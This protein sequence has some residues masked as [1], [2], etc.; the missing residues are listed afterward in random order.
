VCDNVCIYIAGSEV[1]SNCLADK[2]K[3]AAGINTAC[4]VCAV[5]KYQG[6]GRRQHKYKAASGVNL[7]CDICEA[8]KYKA[9]STRGHLDIQ[10]CKNI[11]KVVFDKVCTYVAGST[12]CTRCTVGKFQSTAG[13][14]INCATG[15]Y[16]NVTGATTCL[17]CS[18]D[19]CPFPGTFGLRSCTPKT[20]KVCEVYGHN[21]PTIGKL[22]DPHKEPLLLILGVPDQ[23][24]LFRH[25]KSCLVIQL[26]YQPEC[27]F[28][29]M[30]DTDV[31]F[32]LYYRSCPYKR[33]DLY[34]P[35]IPASL[36]TLGRFECAVAS[37]PAPHDLRI[38]SPLTLTLVFCV[39]SGR[40]QK[41][42]PEFFLPSAHRR[43][44]LCPCAPTLVSSSSPSSRC[45]PLGMSFS[46]LIFS[47]LE[48]LPTF[49]LFLLPCS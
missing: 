45:L 5:G 25:S 48:V 1:C 21:V 19:S 13:S 20:N 49:K 26:E 22:P 36:Q 31:T 47:P 23:S 46:S 28:V 9:P 6:S 39:P 4:D 15:T 14:S 44:G 40:L 32:L 30:T 35:S 34:L 43:F 33:H 12:C 7:V 37:A 17:E 38:I 27:P 3:T 8:G 41:F 42:G 16:I 24:R 10:R 11:H 18:Q 2:Y 29:Q